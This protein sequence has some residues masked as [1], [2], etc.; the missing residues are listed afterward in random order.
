[1]T[2]M[3]PLSSGTSRSATPEI[4]QWILEPPSSSGVMSSPTTALTSGGPPRAMWLVPLTIGTKS[5]RAGI[6]AVPAAPG[7]IIAATIGTTP[8]M[9]DC[10]RKRK[11]DWA[12]VEPMASWMRAPA[13]S[14]SQIIGIRLV[15]AISRARLHLT[16]AV[17]PI[18]P[19]MTVKS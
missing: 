3:H 11:P 12:K 13:E 14:M 5:A 15:S 18:E 19:A 16:S 10:S 1:M 6:Y 2:W 7:P 8:D 17:R 9:I 4:S